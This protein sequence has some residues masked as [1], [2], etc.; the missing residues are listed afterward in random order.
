MFGWLI[1]K[2]FLEP[3]SKTVEKFSLY[4]KTIFFRQFGKVQIS[5]LKHFTKILKILI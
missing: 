5:R 3:N 2:K 4:L 1:W